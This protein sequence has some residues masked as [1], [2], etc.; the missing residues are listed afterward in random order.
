MK[1][2]EI[3]TESTKLKEKAPVNVGKHVWS[4]VKGAFGSTKGKADVDVGSRATQIYQK[5][6]DYALR[7]GMDMSMM[8]VKSLQQ[9]F[10]GQG[11]V[12]PKDAVAGATNLDLTDK[13]TSNHFWT[14][15]AQQAYAKAG[16]GGA[17]LG[18][19]YGVPAKPAKKKAAPAAAASTAAP[20]GANDFASLKAA[21]S[22][23]KGNL[24]PNQINALIKA[25]TGP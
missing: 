18:Q 8:P 20:A 17:K 13:T 22:G 10:K 14:S 9:W 6:N 25:L 1:A 24:N 12:F 3:I 16:S 11:L 15:A 2:K 19:S 23:A 4:A 21:L 7:S 5:F